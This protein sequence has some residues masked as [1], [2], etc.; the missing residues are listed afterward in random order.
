MR[1]LLDTNILVRAHPK[2]RGSARSLLLTIAHS[3]DH[4]LILSPFLLEEVERVLAYPRLQGLWPLTPDDIR[5]YT[6]ALDDVG[7]MVDLSPVFPAVLA[8]PKDDPVVETAVLGRADVLCTLDRDFYTPSVV[9]YLRR[10]SIQ[11]IN[12]VQLLLLLRKG[13]VQTGS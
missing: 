1:I 9:E 3:R 5:D 6:Q 7:E 13:S 12:D 4:T 8:D 10:H 2:A 11:L